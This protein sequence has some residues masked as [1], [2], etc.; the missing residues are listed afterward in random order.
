MANT[1]IIA[2]PDV[3][4]YKNVFFVIKIDINRLLF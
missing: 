4:I 2:I 1:A 3:S